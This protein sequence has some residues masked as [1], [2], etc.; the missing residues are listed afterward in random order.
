MIRGQR[1]AKAAVAVV[2]VHPYSGSVGEPVDRRRTTDILV[3]VASMGGRRGGLAAEPGLV[4]Q[5]CDRGAHPERGEGSKH[6]QQVVELVGCH[7]VL[8]AEDGMVL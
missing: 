6:E 3:P 5:R 1:P 8:H 7:A 4:L 2:H